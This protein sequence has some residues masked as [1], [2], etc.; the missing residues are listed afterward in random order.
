[1]ADIYCAPPLSFITSNDTAVSKALAL[2][3]FF[4]TN[5]VSSTIVISDSKQQFFSSISHVAIRLPHATLNERPHSK[6]SSYQIT[7]THTH[8]WIHMSA[9]SQ[10][11]AVLIA[12]MRFVC[13]VRMDST[14]TSAS[15]LESKIAL[16]FKSVSRARIAQICFE[17]CIHMC[18]CV[19]KCWTYSCASQCCHSFYFCQ[20]CRPTTSTYVE[21]TYIHTHSI[22]IAPTWWRAAPALRLK[23][24][25]SCLY[26]C[27]FRFGLSGV[28]VQQ[29]LQQRQQLPARTPHVFMSVYN[30]AMQPC[31]M[32]PR[33][34]V[35][36]TWLELW[37]EAPHGCERASN[38]LFDCLHID[39]T[40]Y[41]YELFGRS[42]RVA[43]DCAAVLVCWP[44]RCDTRGFG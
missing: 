41:E 7:H 37:I 38:V 6:I 34:I 33:T 25:S 29:S 5:A 30:N 10:Y 13:L 23:V 40:T 31:R 8:T 44:G 43:H 24:R 12:T 19:C 4:R 20:P 17:S 15:S 32:P 39:F 14:L 1:M 18:L 2:P 26:Y 36:A 21:R 35:S 22:I 3:F 9:C 27:Q 42:E 28:G 16:S 11:A